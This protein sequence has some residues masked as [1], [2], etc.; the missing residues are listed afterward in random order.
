MIDDDF[1]SLLEANGEVDTTAAP[2]ANTDPAP[3]D[4][5][6]TTTGE[7]GGEEDTGDMSDGEDGTTPEPIDPDSLLKPYYTFLQIEK[8]ET[9]LKKII[10][11]LGNEVSSEFSKEVDPFLTSLSKIQE[12]KRL[13]D[14]STPEKIDKQLNKIQKEVLSNLRQIKYT[15]NKLDDKLEQNKIA[16]DSYR[17]FKK[18]RGTYNKCENEKECEE[19]KK[20]MTKENE[21]W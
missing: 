1:Y 8:T 18:E 16:E 11:F 14:Y 3:T 21:Q 7:D 15:K 19:N 20:M 4:D 9:N 17:S 12:L 13:F 5:T 2:P 6:G 10:S